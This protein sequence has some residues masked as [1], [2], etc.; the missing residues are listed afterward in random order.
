MPGIAPVIDPGDVDREEDAEHA[1]AHHAA[2][3]GHERVRR[4]RGE[5]GPLPD[6]AHEVPVEPGEEDAED[7]REGEVAGALAELRDQDRG[8]ERG[9]ERPRDREDLGQPE[10]ARA[11]VIVL[12]E[13][14][15]RAR[16]AG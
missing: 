13:L 8:E 15:A 2:H 1:V 5:V 12:G 4:A 16:S 7:H 11:L 10:E 14:R 3:A 6:A 9:D